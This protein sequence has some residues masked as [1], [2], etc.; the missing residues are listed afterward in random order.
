[1]TSTES[2]PQ[3]HIAMENCATEEAAIQPKR[4]PEKPPA[5]MNTAQSLFRGHSKA[6]QEAIA[7]ERVPPPGTVLP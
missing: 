1:V 5:T 2:L 3:N 6:K 4:Q 7:A